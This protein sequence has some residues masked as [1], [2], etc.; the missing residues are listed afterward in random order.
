[1][2]AVVQLS[3]R[4]VHSK[5]WGL[6]EVGRVQRSPPF[7]G[8]LRDFLDW[9]LVDLNYEGISGIYVAC[10]IDE[11]ICFLGFVSRKE[12]WGHLCT[13]KF[14]TERLQQKRAHYI[15]FCRNLEKLLSPL[16]MDVEY[17]DL[18]F[19][20]SLNWQE[21]LSAFDNSSVFLLGAKYSGENYNSSSVFIRSSK[22]SWSWDH[23]LS[24]DVVIETVKAETMAVGA[25][26]SANSEDAIPSS[27]QNCL[28]PKDL[29]ISGDSIPE[30]FQ[31]EP[32]AVAA[33]AAYGADG[34][35]DFPSVLVAA[36][37]G[38]RKGTLRKEALD[39]ELNSMVKYGLR[40]GILKGELFS[41]YLSNQGNDGMTVPDLSRCV[42]ISE[43]NLADTTEE[44][45]LP[46]LSY[47]SRNTD[48]DFKNSSND[49]FDSDLGTFNLEK[50]GGGVE[51]DQELN[52]GVVVRDTVIVDNQDGTKGDACTDKS[53]TAGLSNNE[54]KQETK[55]KPEAD[56]EAT[57]NEHVIK[58]AELENAVS[59]KSES[60]ESADLSPVLNTTIKLDETNHYSDEDDKESE[61]E[62][63]VTDEEFKGMVL[64]GSEAA[65]HFLKELGQVL[66]G[67]SHSSVESSRDHSQR[68]G[69]Q[70]I[71]D[72]DEEVD[73][74]EEGDRKEL[75]NSVALAAILKANAELHSVYSVLNLM[76]MGRTSSDSDGP[77]QILFTSI[78][79]LDYALVHLGEEED[80]LMPDARLSSISPTLARVPGGTEKE[81]EQREQGLKGT[82]QNGSIEK[83]L[84]GIVSAA[85]DILM[86][87]KARNELGNEDWITEIIARKWEVSTTERAKDEVRDELENSDSE[88]QKSPEVNY[89]KID[90][91]DELLS[92]DLKLE[93]EWQQV[94]TCFEMNMASSTPDMPAMYR[95]LF[96]Q[97]SAIQQ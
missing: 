61:I 63:S 13:R 27:N 18:D 68:I 84:N 97:P 48:D 57:K 16:L 36:G 93:N 66:G 96:I 70:I 65:K 40:L 2:G 69:G 80:A 24:S 45:E 14:L 47:D 78:E 58:G 4:H 56:S 11:R 35:D 31:A 53:E 82:I 15:R 88:L 50:T 64:E 95:G 37:F 41:I 90:E 10:V 55:T 19:N 30:T 43:L 92:E 71:S 72:S 21:V 74:D 6:L 54:E 85:I 22:L 28:D 77:N 67:G 12:A 33:A 8:S 17:R 51:K 86:S 83:S 59:G 38:S 52:V 49:D 5:K 89:K 39:K 79:E 73:T 20:S 42:H 75:F 60:L 23:I 62:G 34:E 3:Q 26:S 94:S 25:A 32:V 91:S 7:L 29:L 87:F 81:A 1:M 44:L 9:M 76:K 46:M